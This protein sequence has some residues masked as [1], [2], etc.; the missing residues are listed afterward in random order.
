MPQIY[1]RDFNDEKPMNISSTGA[2]VKSES[3]LRSLVG[4]EW[5]TNRF[6]CPKQAIIDIRHRD[7]NDV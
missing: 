4:F 2:T 1:R 7:R 6:I 5:K 3:T